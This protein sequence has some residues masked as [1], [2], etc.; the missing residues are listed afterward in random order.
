MVYYFVKLAV[1]LVGIH[2]EIDEYCHEKDC[3]SNVNLAK[4]QLA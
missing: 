3:M 4:A 1:G 2:D